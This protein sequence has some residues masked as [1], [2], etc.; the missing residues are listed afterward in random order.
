[1]TNP[2]SV[3][4]FDLWNAY[5]SV[6][7][8]SWGPQRIFTGI[9]K[10][11]TDSLNLNLPTFIRE[12]SSNGIELGNLKPGTQYMVKD[13]ATAALLLHLDQE[14]SLLLGNSP[15]IYRGQADHSG[16]TIEASIDRTTKIGLEREH[17]TGIFGTMLFNFMLQNV[18]WQ[19]GDWW[20][21]EWHLDEFSTMAMARHHGMSSP[22][23]DLTVDPSVAVMFAHDQA[24]N[25]RAENAVV[26]RFAVGDLGDNAVLSLPPPP[27]LRSGRQHGVYYRS[28]LVNEK[29]GTPLT[30]KTIRICFPTYSQK[31]Y[32][33][34]L[35]REGEMID[36]MH[37]DPL[38]KAIETHIRKYMENMAVVAIHDEYLQNKSEFPSSLRYMG[39]F[40]LLIIANED[41]IIT[42]KD[43]R[44]LYSP[45]DE[46]VEWFILTTDIFHALL[47]ITNVA[48]KVG[49][50]LD[51]VDRFV[52]QNHITLQV[53]LF[54]FMR[55][56]HR[57]SI[58]ENLMPIM[59]VLNTKLLEISIGNTGIISQDMIL[60]GTD[61]IPGE[62]RKLP[63]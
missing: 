19:V 63:W 49:F 23:I 38:L 43:K 46:M 55:F 47:G 21:K 60:E 3:N 14:I 8:D 13:A 16:W 36:L 45:K 35:L 52:R 33:N 2:T 44:F 54:F 50:Q 59:R 48:G 18:D 30:D 5:R 56:F 6:K 58:F 11:P 9:P 40:S 1:M 29:P 26:F 15:P 61:I 51:M 10:T 41:K 17:L 31:F 27:V 28:L 20:T 62:I 12:L 24:T 39:L 32:N 34:G 7:M 57:T 42:Q 4:S 25:T 53:Y 37:S 22:L